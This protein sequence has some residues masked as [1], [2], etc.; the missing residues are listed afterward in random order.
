MKHAVLSE[1]PIRIALTLGLMLLLAILSLIPGRA[2]SG[3]SLFVWALAAT[4]T[5]LQKLL[6]LL[7]YALLT[8]LWVWTLAAIDSWIVRVSIAVLLAV[9][10]GAV[11]EIAQTRIPGRFGTLTDV[12]LNGAGAVF[13]VLLA[14]LLL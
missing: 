5:P 8:L 10:F 12:L 11:M 9:G 3:D 14:W 1:L 4:P 7:L 13:G 6:H 2:E